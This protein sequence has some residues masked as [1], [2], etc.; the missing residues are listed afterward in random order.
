MNSVPFIILAGGEGTRFKEVDQ[1]ISKIIY[2]INNKPFVGYL[3]EHIYEYEKN[4]EIFI[5]IHEQM[6]EEKNIIL[7]HY[8]KVKFLEESLRLGTG[9]AVEVAFKETKADELVILNGDSYIKLEWE[10]FLNRGQTS[11]CLCHHS[12][13]SQVCE[14][15]NVEVRDDRII[16]FHEKSDVEGEYI[17]AGIYHIKK[18]DILD[19]FKESKW[20][21]EKD[22]LMKKKNLKAYLSNES[23]FD[24][25][26][27]EGLAE[28]QNYLR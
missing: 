21:L 12:K 5:S 10:S 16:S 28:F 11:V 23:L 18:E 22:F 13:A 9:G 26:T 6:I 25:G 17:N 7:K 27:V 14:K 1:N 19:F 3:I 4:A 20:S 24:I 15:G 8:P 2:D